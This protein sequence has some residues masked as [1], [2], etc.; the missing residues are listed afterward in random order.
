[1][2]ISLCMIAKNEEKFIG[3]AIRSVASIISETILVDT[4]STDRTIP[5][6]KELGAKVF[7]QPWLDDF[8]TPRNFGISKASGDWILVLDADEVIAKEDLAK[9]VS[10]LSL[11]NTAIEIT[12]RHYTNDH[13]LSDFTICKGENPELEQGNKGYFESNCVRLFPNHKDIRYEG[14]IHELVEHSL[15]RLKNYKI[16]SSGIRIHHYGHTDE[17]KKSKNKTLIYTPLG[18]KKAEENKQDWKAYFELGVEHNVHRRHKESIEAFEKSIPLNPTYLATWINYGYALM[19]SEQYA[20]AKNAFEEAIILDPESSESYCNLGVVGLRT[21]NLEFARAATLKALEIKPDYVNASLNLA[22][23]LLEMKRVSESI[24]VLREV[25][26]IL[27][28]CT[29]AKV[30]LGTYYLFSGM[31]ALGEKC[32]LE[33]LDSAPEDER[34]YLNLFALY[35]Q[36][37][38][39]EKRAMLLETCK[40]KAPHILSKIGI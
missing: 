1:M 37:H 2:K 8:S 20:K 12:Q 14:R 10:Y 11:K 16:I 39:N 6:A 32:L 29:Q 15:N 30:D 36:Q 27:P 19:E 31:E 34:A 28:S 38:D 7:E 24:L 35:T 21:R 40:V 9:V 26:R 17:V 4:G 25:L 23:I 5:I 18:E 13:R 22:R 3:Q 33:A